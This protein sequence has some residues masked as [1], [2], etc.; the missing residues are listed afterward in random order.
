MASVFSEGVAHIS[1]DAST[2]SGSYGLE[3]PSSAITDTAKIEAS[4]STTASPSQVPGSKNAG[5][6]SLVALPHSAISMTPGALFRVSDLIE[7]TTSKAW[8]STKAAAYASSDAWTD[9]DVI[10]SKGP[11]PVITDTVKV[12]TTIGMAAGPSQEP[13]SKYTG[14]PQPNSTPGLGA[15]IVSAFGGTS[16]SVD[17]SDQIHGPK[18][19]T[20]T[21][22]IFGGGTVLAASAFAAVLEPIGPSDHTSMAQL[23][24]YGGNNPEDP[25]VMHGHTIS[26]NTPPTINNAALAY[27]SGIFYSNGDPVAMS[28]HPEIVEG[29]VFTAGGMTISLDSSYHPDGTA[30]PAIEINHHIITEGSSATIIDGTTI[31]FSDNSIYI[32]SEAYAAPTQVNRTPNPS[33]NFVD[34]LMSAAYTSNKLAL[35]TVGGETA[36]IIDHSRIAIGSATIVLG[37]H[38]TTLDHQF[39]SLGTDGLIIGSTTVSMPSENPTAPYTT[40]IDGMTFTANSRAF[41]EG[42]VTLSSGGP[43]ATI[44]GTM[45]SVGS[46]GD[47]VTGIGIGGFGNITASVQEFTGES[48][49]RWRP[50]MLFLMVSMGLCMTCAVLL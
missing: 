48:G 24:P 30:I 21:S 36:S 35:L 3:G 33:A 19:T 15:I 44:D 7:S 34:Q 8:G 32:G 13:D 49:R 37:A 26:E 23:L 42:S 27:T 16:K 29:P 2:D 40:V 39:I 41:V 18:T 43:G 12:E 45:I 1:S 46:V 25:I 22:A 17:P 38:A 11:S 31:A 28:Y 20:T 5:Y 6:P 47:L 10:S 9:A 14:N 50:C 4:T